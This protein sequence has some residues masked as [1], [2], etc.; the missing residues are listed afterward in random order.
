M[1]EGLIECVET[2]KERLE[3]HGDHIGAYES[4]T[5]T[6]LI[7]PLLKALGWDP[8]DPAR[9]EIEPKVKGGWA[10]YA[11][12]SDDGRKLM[13]IEAKKASD[14]KPATLQ[15]ATYTFTYNTHNS[16]KIG[17]C[18]WTNGRR[19]IVW[20]VFRQEPVLEVDLGTG[21]PAECA[22]RLLGLWRGSLKQA[23]VRKPER[24]MLNFTAPRPDPPVPPPAPTPKPKPVELSGLKGPNKTYFKVVVGGQANDGYYVQKLASG[25]WTP[26]PKMR[27]DYFGG[28][29][30][31]VWFATEEEARAAVLKKLGR[32]R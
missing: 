20:D 21:A 13:F 24:P 27:A 2:L 1:V 4:R 26:G 22:F 7:D 28:K 29:N 3:K 31:K 6:A 5:R 23:T 11:L 15:T 9:V 14:S 30:V 17:H 32:V 18:A 25:R 16:P 12:L 8:A 10:D 19:W